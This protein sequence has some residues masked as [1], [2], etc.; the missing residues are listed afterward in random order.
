[1]C[2]LKVKNLFFDLLVKS[3]IEIENIKTK[4]IF[5]GV[6]KSKENYVEKFCDNNTLPIRN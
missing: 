5:S 6:W 2:E 4:E 1:M 3:I